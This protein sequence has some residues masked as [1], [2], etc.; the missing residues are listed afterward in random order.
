MTPDLD[1]VPEADWFS[2]A[3]AGVLDFYGI[4]REIDPCSECALEM[5]LRA[6]DPVRESADLTALTIDQDVS[7]KA[8]RT[9][10]ALGFETGV[11]IDGNPGPFSPEEI[12]LMIADYCKRT[13]NYDLIVLGD[14]SSDGN[15][16]KTQFL[17]TEY[18]GY[19][20]AHRVIEFAFTDDTRVRIKREIPGGFCE[21]TRQLPLVISVGDVPGML[22]RVPT[23]MQRKKASDKQVCVIPYDET[24]KSAASSVSLT[25]L[26]YIDQSRSGEI[27]HADS[28]SQAA[29]ILWDRFVRGMMK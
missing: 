4:K 25:G 24:Y 29:Q 10:F 6:A 21:E 9:L 14:Q 16:R 20:I 13:R 3:S 19:P 5:T 18:L 15:N 2:G 28:P 27:I 7:E 17:L 26:D 1:Q 22:L 11:R 12:A 23:L 8:L